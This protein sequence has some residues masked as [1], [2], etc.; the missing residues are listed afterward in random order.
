MNQ[1]SSFCVEME[2]GLKNID[3]ESSRLFVCIN[4]FREEFKLPLGLLYVG[5]VKGLLK[6]RLKNAE[7]PLKDRG[8]TAK[9]NPYISKKRTSKD[10][11]KTSE[12]Y[13]AGVSGKFGKSGADISPSIK[14]VGGSEQSG[15]I[16]DAFSFDD[17]QVSAGGTKESP[18]WFYEV[19]TKENYLKGKFDNQNLGLVKI[20]EKPSSM[21]A[22]FKASSRDLHITGTE[23]IWPSD[24]NNQNRIVRKIVILKWLKNKI[25]PYL[26]HE[27]IS[28]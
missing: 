25:K 11:T 20:T 12:K 23:G 1:K 22:I 5:I 26:A 2:F 19:K 17:Y 9:L 3:Q 16:D 10:G 8:S 15:E 28:L 13:E 18:H 24:M 27:S 6:L 7:M 4:F 21:E 14:N